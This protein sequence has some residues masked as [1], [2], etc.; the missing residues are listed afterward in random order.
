MSQAL[1][2][3]QYCMVPH[4]HRVRS[5]HIGEKHPYQINNACNEDLTWMQAQFVKVLR[6]CSRK[7][8][9]DVGKNDVLH[10]SNIY[11]GAKKRQSEWNKYIVK[12]ITAYYSIGTFGKFYKTI[13]VPYLY[14]KLA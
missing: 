13:C 1:T 3:V 8:T 9:K 10:V 11:E 5:L 7:Y 2:A 4:P 14:Q 12:Y 6:Y